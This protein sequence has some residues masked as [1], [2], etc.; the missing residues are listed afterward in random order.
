[1]EAP[2]LCLFLKLLHTSK[3]CNSFICNIASYEL[4]LQKNFLHES[5]FYSL[6]DSSIFPNMHPDYD[7]PLLVS[8]LFK[9]GTYV[10]GCYL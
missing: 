9:R 6:Y 1:M 4:Y 8:F 2:F 3:Q 5:R 7:L 10:C